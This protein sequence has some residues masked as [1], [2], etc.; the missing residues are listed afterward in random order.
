M[1]GSV[2]LMCKRGELSAGVV[3]SR[4]AT[5]QDLVEKLCRK[6]SDLKGGAL[7]L[8]RINAID[9]ILMVSGSSSTCSTVDPCSSDGGSIASCGELTVVNEEFNAVHTCDSAV[10]TN[11]ISQVS[12]HFI[13]RLVTEEL[14]SRPFKRAI[15]IMHYLKEDYGVDVTYRRSHMG[16]QKAKD[17]AFGSYSASFADLKWYVQKFK[18]SMY[19]GSLLSACTKDGN[20]GLYPIWFAIVDGETYESWHWFLEQMRVFLEIT[21]TTPERNVVFIS[22]RNIGLLHAVADVFPGASH[23]YCLVHLKKNLRTRLGGV[24]M[25]QKRYLVELFGKCAYALNLELFNELLAKLEHEGGDKMRDLLSDLDVKHWAHAHFPGHRY[26]ELS[27]NLAECFNRWIKDER[28]LPVMQLVDA[29]R[30][31]LMEQMSCRKEE[32]LTWKTTV[33]PTWDKRLA[34]LFQ[35]SRTWVVRKSSA[36]VYDVRGNPSNT[37]NIRQRRCTC[38]EWQL[39]CFPCVH[40]V[41]AIRKSG[42]DLNDFVEPCYLVYSFREAYSKSI[43]PIPTVYKP[44]FVADSDD[45]ILPPLQ[46]RPAGRPRTERVSPIWKTTRKRLCSRCGTVARHNKRTCKKPLLS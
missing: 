33:C 15:D 16:L 44:D 36:D 2:I 45:V 20:Q 46:R 43:E 10:L 11:K 5:F 41:C 14:R 28:C 13:G 27:S 31:K 25:D 30:M 22:D 9:V 26:S 6:W 17:S 35:F 23:S 29:I 18:E 21:L 42:C 19:K 4:R 37:V 38:R 40:A 12:C 3:L 1:E 39:N 24:A 7:L 34:G 8:L 32:S